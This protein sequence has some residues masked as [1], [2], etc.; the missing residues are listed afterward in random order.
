[1]NQ[2]IKEQ[3]YE[4]LIGGLYKPG[5]EANIRTVFPTLSESQ[6]HHLAVLYSSGNRGEIGD[7]IMNIIDAYWVMRADVVATE[8]AKE[9]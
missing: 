2:E 3:I 5:K 1:M 4:N 8:I 6:A 9:F 7:F